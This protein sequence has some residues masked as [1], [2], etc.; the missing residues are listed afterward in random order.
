MTNPSSPLPA[1]IRD[2]VAA[3]SQEDV[4]KEVEPLLRRA[5]RVVT[6]EWKLASKADPGMKIDAKSFVRDLSSGALNADL[7][8]LFA[9]NHRFIAQLSEKNRRAA[10]ETYDFV[11]TAMPRAM[12]NAKQMDVIAARKSEILRLQGSI[13]DLGVYKGSS[14]RA[15]AGIFPDQTIHGFDSFEGLPEDW[16]HVLK[17]AFGDVKGVLPN[18]PDNVLLYKGW[19]DD[20]LPIW[21]EDTRTS[22]SRC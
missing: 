15:L 9:G 13:L 2:F 22:L 6:D 19:F 18:M 3:I 1:A 21:F 4:W 20:T 17:G 14:T 16:S 11:D 12:F 5:V 7:Q 8:N 10:V